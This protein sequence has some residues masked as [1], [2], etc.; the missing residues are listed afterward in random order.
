[1]IEI[2]ISTT[3]PD[4]GEYAAAVVGAGARARLLTFDPHTLDAQLAAT[5]GV[6]VSGGGDVDPAHYGGSATAAD[7]V[8]RRRDEFEIAL[9]RRARECGLP[10]LCICRGL[11]IA[12][13]AFGG[14]L[15]EDIATAVN[16]ETAALH[17]RKVGATIERGLIAGHDVT[18]LADSQLAAIVRASVI[19][20]GSR[21]HQSL[22]RIAPDLRIV[23]RT[24]D[25]IAEAAQARFPTPFWLGVQWHPESTLDS[26][27]GGASRAIFA[28]FVAAAAR[29]GPLRGLA[30]T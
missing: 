10:T 26:A 20:T 3:F 16:P 9:L 22:D 21:H 27:D 13:V 28:A 25:G 23:A 24:P 2:A 17:R 8:D 7:G 14:S 4:G 1:M 11:Q 29:C 19:P 5:A 18:I 15:V 30:P 6:L 12:N